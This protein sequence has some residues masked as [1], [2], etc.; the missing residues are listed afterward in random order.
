MDFH[1]FSYGLCISYDFLGFTMDFPWLSYGF[2]MDFPGGS[3]LK[4]LPRSVR[5]PRPWHCGSMRPCSV[6]A[7]CWWPTSGGPTARCSM[8]GHRKPPFSMGT[9]IGN[10]RKTKGKPENGGCSLDFYGY[11]TPVSLNMAGK[12]LNWMGGFLG[13]AANFQWHAVFDEFWLPV[14]KCRSKLAIHLWN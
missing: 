4:L 7:G 8:G 1:W 3:N 9:T 5:P 2:P 6:A 14:G 11:Y 13:K 12:S 10:Y